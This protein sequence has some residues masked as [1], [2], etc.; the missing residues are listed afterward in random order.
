VRTPDLDVPALREAMD[1]WAQ[2]AELTVVLL[3]DAQ[4]VADMY[5]AVLHPA[6]PPQEGEK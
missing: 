5:R 2:A 1:R 6:S 3:E 4:I